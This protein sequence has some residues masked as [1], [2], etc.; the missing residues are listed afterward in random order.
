MKKSKLLYCRYLPRYD[1]VWSSIING[2]PT[3]CFCRARYMP[4]TGNTSIYQKGTISIGK[5]HAQNNA[6]LY[7]GSIEKLTGQDALPLGNPIQLPAGSIISLGFINLPAPAAIR[8]PMML[9]VRRMIRISIKAVLNIILGFCASLLIPIPF[10]LIGI[11]AF[12]FIPNSI[13]FLR[14]LNQ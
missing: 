8:T 5:L 9:G 12:D 10:L 7:P 6:F 1:W 14:F 13:G 3:E 2:I 4:D 11:I